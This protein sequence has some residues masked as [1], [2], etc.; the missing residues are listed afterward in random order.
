M[1]NIAWN[2]FELAVNV[3]ESGL[4][5]AFV[6]RFLDAPPREAENR[7][8][9]VLGWAGYF[10]IVSV[11]NH[12][13]V[14]EGLAGFVYVA[15]L[16]L[17]SLILEGSLLKKLMASAMTLACVILISSTVTNTVSVLADVPLEI[18]Y[19][20]GN[21]YRLLSILAVQLML[22]YCFQMLVK[23][24]QRN[25]VIFQK[26]EWLVIISVLVLSLLVMVF[27]HILAM[28]AHLADAQARLLVLANLCIIA[29]NLLL[30]YLVNRLSLNN[31]RIRTMQEQ[32]Q[33]LLR[34]NHYAESI[35]QQAD[36]LQRM[37]H[38]W[39][40]HLSV[41]Q[42]MLKGGETE[43]ALAYLQT[44]QEH[45]I[46]A[47]LT[48]LQ[49]NSNNRYL[50]ALLHVKFTMAKECNIQVEC[51]C[52]AEFECYSD[53][54]LC[55]LIGNLMDN[56]IEACQRIEEGRRYIRLTIRG[57]SERMII[58]TANTVNAPV[59]ETNPHMET[60]KYNGTTHGYGMQT[61][62]SIARQYNGDLDYYDQDGIFHM[63]VV[64]YGTS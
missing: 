38:D 31:H 39:K 64:L 21:F 51:N 57:N 42:T 35:Q 62:R 61:I 50:D 26:T 60:N 22:V 2:L 9:F 44:Y 53:V 19:T 6:F 49:V 12:I 14:Y 45:E 4:I 7:W 16:F 23:I 13:T 33:L 8:K 63:Q 56:A 37:R 48:G 27:L 10:A 5:M 1:M 52:Q 11:M 47:V 15:Y 3:W 24:F 32:Q 20:T 30:F 55:N 58:E 41:V 46:T 54:K 34:E 36:T 28:E 25:G 43:R 40:Q 29:M 18:I 59:T 17:F